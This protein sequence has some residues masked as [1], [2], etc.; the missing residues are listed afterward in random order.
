MKQLVKGV[1]RRLGYRIQ[2]IGVGEAWDAFEFQK[3]LIE[4][5]APTIFDVGAHV[6]TMTHKYI[7]QFP[8]ASVYCFEPFPES[9]HKLVETTKS[10]PNV[11]PYEIAL[12]SSRGRALLNAN[13][14]PPTNSLL[15]T[16]ARGSSYWGKGLIDTTSQ[17]EV[18]TTT[19]DSFCEEAGIVSIDILKLDVQGAEFA[20]LQGAAAMLAQERVSL[21]YTEVITA[22]T[23][24]E[25]HKLHEYLALLD[26]FG[27]E[28]LDFFDPVRKQNQLLQA[29][30][31]FV[32]SS[33]KKESEKLLT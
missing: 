18:E 6:G 13:L 10:F 33:F 21:V 16:D 24:R 32:S 7:Q 3:I 20:V 12:S 15:E 22:P 19:I 2:R 31:V 14:F 27:F 28:L 29:D 4:Q 1:L 17:I 8:L 9:F 25:Q 11:R 26:S 23:Y 30:L 5:A